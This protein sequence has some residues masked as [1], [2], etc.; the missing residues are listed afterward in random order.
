MADSYRIE[1]VGDRRVERGLR[2]VE[3]ELHLR[4]LEASHEAATLAEES[5]RANA[6]SPKSGTQPQ[7]FGIFSRVVTTQRLAGSAKG[8]VP[9]FDRNYEVRLGIHDGTVAAYVEAGT[10]IF[11]TPERGGP[12]RPYVVKA[13]GKALAPFDTPEGEIFRKSARIPGTHPHPF[14]AESALEVE[15]EIEALYEHAVSES[16]RTI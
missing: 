7:G 4:L 9:I 16:V 3:G 15:D 6:P 14:L 8:G 1:I 5:T 13:H 12:F 2:D 11:A 10:G